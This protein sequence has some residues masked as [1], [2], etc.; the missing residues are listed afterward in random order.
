M[1]R[2]T[3]PALLLIA[4]IQ[5]PAFAQ[6]SGGS[7]NQGG[8]SPPVVFPSVTVSTR[9][10]V[11]DLSTP[12]PEKPDLEFLQTDSEGTTTIF[13]HEYEVVTTQDDYHSFRKIRLQPDPGSR[14]IGSKVKR[15]RAF[16]D[17]R[18]YPGG[19]YL[20]YLETE[21]AVQLLDNH[22]NWLTRFEGSAQS[23]TTTRARTLTVPSLLT[24]SVSVGDPQWRDLRSYFQS[25]IW[26][27]REFRIKF[28]GTVVREGAVIMEVEHH[29]GT[30]SYKQRLYVSDLAGPVQIDSTPIELPALNV[31]ANTKVEIESDC[32]L[33][34]AGP[35]IPDNG[36][37][38][39]FRKIELKHSLWHGTPLP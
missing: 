34:H 2:R 18:W 31:P 38:Q 13:S 20:A 7:G 11:D 21:Q 26:A 8:T 39:D 4:T 30:P 24:H 28:N 29:N 9:A 37:Y 10:H 27:T 5:V 35:G 33:Y 12:A 14:E 25:G 19:Q 15:A 36:F 1:L 17:E 22:T 3:L 16:I 6:S 32:S 23:H